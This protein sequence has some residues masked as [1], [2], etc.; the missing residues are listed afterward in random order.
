MST[1]LTSPIV[2]RN[3]HTIKVLSVRRVSSPGPGKQDIRSLEDQGDLHKRWLKDHV[4]GTCDI[5]VIAGSGSGEYLGRAEFLELVELVETGQYDL[6]LAEDLGRIVRRMQAHEFCELC[7][8]H[9]TRLIA[10]NDHIDTGVDGWQDHSIISAWHHERS[11]RDTSERIKRSHRSRFQ[12]GGTASLPIYGYQKKPDA[13]SDKDWERLPEAE[14]VY[15]KWFERLDRGETYAEI[16]DW[17]NELGIAPGPYCRNNKWDCRMVSR[18]TH[19]PILKG[20]RFRNKRKTRR[21][22]DGKY[23]SVKASPEDLLTRHVPHLA[24]FEED[25]YDRVVAKS[26][27][28]N[29]KYRRNGNGGPDPCANRP[30]KRTRFP[31]QSIYCGVCGRMF[32]FGGHGQTDRLMCQG[33]REHKCWNGITVDAPLTARKVAEALFAEIEGLVDFDSSFLAMVNEEADRLDGVRE[34]HLRDLDKKLNQVRREIDNLMKFIRSGDSS[35]RVRAELRRLEEEEKQFLFEKDENER[36]PSN[37]VVVP[38]VE[39]IK[40][41]AREAFKDLAVDSY[42]FG[43]RLRA[44][45]GKIMVYPFRSIDG[46]HLELR[47]KFKLQLANLLPDQRQRDALKQ[48]LERELRLDLFEP[49]QRV[50]FRERVVA[51]RQEMTEREAAKKL[52]ITITAACRAYALHRNMQQQGLA[53]PYVLVKEPP[54]DYTKLRRHHH[55]R[56]NFEPLPGHTLEW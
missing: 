39:K 54:L 37:A 56:Y 33:A 26:D 2:P 55:P 34:T 41:V 52:G 15:R 14:D 31:G 36:I 47:G 3:G 35:N 11:N 48:P 4:H 46:G 12:H 20:E 43:K 18:I 30:K 38:P 49:P 44:L 32:V 5:K 27:A 10:I 51:L 23:K 28:R 42:E 19:N 1:S 8:D 40:Q 24:F 13:K 25:Y 16:S 9:Q 53:D 7:D 29:I 21:R 22:S 6:V 17:L 45:T 50:E